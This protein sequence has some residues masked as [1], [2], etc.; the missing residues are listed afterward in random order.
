MKR[1]LIKSSRL[2]LEHSIGDEGLRFVHVVLSEE[3]RRFDHPL[4]FHPTI[5][6]SYG[7]H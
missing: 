3:S 2:S 1:M 7:V 6:M 4:D 5:V